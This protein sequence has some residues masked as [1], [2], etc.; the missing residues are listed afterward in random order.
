[1]NR[2]R[3]IET[4]VISIFALLFTIYGLGAIWR[5]SFCAIDGQRYFAFADDGLIALRYG[6]NLARGKGLVWNPGER[7]EGISNTLWALQAG[8][9][10]L[11]LGKRFVPPV[12]QLSAICWLLVTAWCF[13]GIA[14]T[15]RAAGQDR[16]W[17]VT[18][19]SLAFLLPLS[20]SPLIIWSLR[21]METSL[22]AALVAGALLMFLRARR[23]PAFRGSILLGLS[24]VT[25]PDCIVPAGAIFG[26]RLLGVVMKKHNWRHLLLELAPFISILATLAAFRF[27]YFGSFTPNTY[28]L[29]IG[30]MSLSERILLNG[31]GYIKPFLSMSLPLVIAVALSLAV[32]PTVHKLMLAAIPASMLLYTVCIGGDAFGNWRF[33]APYVP[34]AFLLVL[35]DFPRLDRLLQ[36]HLPDNSAGRL[37][38]RGCVGLAVV[39]LLVAARPPLYQSYFQS[40]SVPRAD[41]VANIN[42]AIWLNDVLEPSA[43]VGVFYAGSVPFYADFYAFDFLGKSDRRI[44]SLPPDKS[45]AVSWFGLTSAPGHN[46]YDLEY[47]I[48]RRRPTCVQGLKWGGQDVTEAALRL[49]V[50]VPVAFATLLSHGERTLLLLRD[51]PL[52]RW[53]RIEDPAPKQV[54]SGSNNPETGNCPVE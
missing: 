48:L 14:H 25:R 16:F 24:C 53:S 47:S 29:K 36:R 3:S 35:L 46:K 31:L 32:R 43:S 39:L 15:L 28:V 10:S 37:C 18:G 44:A 38:H 49:Y 34:F 45:G 11:F 54:Q 20:Y 12:M 4:G 9:L 13:R 42:T 23:R 6:W 41:D 22:Q 27:L 17:S 26:A 33:L 5:Q 50:P 1:M 2:D 52:V 51:S 19:G 8:G 21:G 7:I 30:G 40:L